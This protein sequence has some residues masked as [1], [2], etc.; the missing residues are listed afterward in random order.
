MVLTFQAERI[1]RV[2]L[3]EVA[4][5]QKSALL[6]C[7]LMASCVALNGSIV[8]HSALA[9]DVWSNNSLVDPKTKLLCCS[10]A[11]AE[12]LDKDKVKIVSGGYKLVDTGE[13]VPESRAQPSPDGEYWVFH[14]HGNLQCFF[15]PLQ[16][17]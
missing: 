12:H 6:K 13:I 2:A 4:V 9:H 15:A 3:G 10:G 16:G 7:T 8:L 1:L 14:Y 17:V 11:E 5:M